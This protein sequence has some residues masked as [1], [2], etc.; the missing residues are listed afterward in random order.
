L[1]VRIAIIFPIMM[2]SLDPKK[3]PSSWEA[4][5]SSFNIG[6]YMGGC[7]CYAICFDS[8][9]LLLFFLI[10]ADGLP[11]PEFDIINT[12]APLWRDPLYDGAA[13]PTISYD[14]LTQEWFIH[15]TQ[16]RASDRT[17]GNRSWC[18]GTD[19]AA[20]VSA[21]KGITW[22]Y[23]GP[24][25]G[26]KW[27]EGINTFWAPDIFLGKD[28]RHHM[29]LTY[30]SHRTL[31]GGGTSWRG[32]TQRVAHYSS[33]SLRGPWHFYGLIPNLVN[34]LDPDVRQLPDGRY[35]MWFKDIRAR[36]QTGAAISSDLK[37]WERL[38]ALETNGVPPHEAPNCFFWKGFWWLLVDPMAA[39]GI[40]VLRSTDAL[41]WV[42]QEQPIL[43]F[44]GVRPLDAN[45][46]NHV[47]V[48]VLDNERALVFYFV[49]P[50]R[51]CCESDRRSL[52]F[53]YSAIQVAELEFV[54]SP[55]GQGRLKCRRDKY[56]QWK[57]RVK[58][59]EK[60]GT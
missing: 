47:D 57:R 46:G 60:E 6:T 44:G 22:K 30:I 10:F 9:L 24:A 55:D 17:L 18:F 51:P 40:F 11:A 58:K 1:D 25:R 12:K 52:Q 14:F 8:L 35:K 50:G 53:R 34:V 48:V 3:S 16:R 49:H 7:F 15:Y 20:A 37:V 31:R 13:D 33:E 41:N 5:Q 32:G 19:I 23:L 36:G 42:R 43:H 27:E 56:V 4:L 21:D 2:I 39:P 59:R 54:R 38:S 26:L 29:F 45:D 28:G